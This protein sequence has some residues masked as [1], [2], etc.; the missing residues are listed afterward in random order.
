MNTQLPSNSR[1]S[2]LK[3]LT[4]T[5]AAG[6]AMPNLLLRAQDIPA[7]KKLG[8][9]CIGVGGKGFSDMTSAAWQNE[10]VAIC[11]VDAN[12]LAKA[13][14][15]FPNA[16]QYSDFREMLEKEKGIDG[17]T[18][19]T[20]DHSHYP[21]AMHAISLGKHICVQKPLVNT[22]WEARELHKAASKKGIITQMGNQ[23]HTYEENRLLKE[24]LDAGAIGKISEIHVWTNRQVWP[25][26]TATAP[27]PVQPVPD[28]LDWKLWLAQSPDADYRPQIHPFHWR[29]LFEYGAGALGDMGCHNLDPIV[30]ALGL[31]V[32]D[33]IEATAND[34]T[35]TAWPAGAK[36]EYV[37]ENV[38][39]HGAIKLYWYEGKNSDGSPCLPPPPEGLTKPMSNVGFYL[40]GADGIIHNEGSQ[41]QKFMILP[42][43]RSVEFL[44]NPPEKS[45]DR[46]PTPGDSQK[47]WSLAIK[48]GKPFPFM[49]QFD[50]AVPLTEL[51]LLGALSIRTGTAIRCDQEKYL[52]TGNDAA[53]RLIKRAQYREGWE[54]TA[55]KI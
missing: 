37:W 5:T 38:P 55:D 30:W 24:Y 15:K 7:G 9:G 12:M 44:A 45:L 39:G 16:R 27:K 53:N 8:I 42:E 50:Y 19:S 43:A 54:Y 33:R 52:A 4:A 17:V 29:G 49:S 20:P 18:I 1:R 28:T 22:L 31:G 13:A 26:G 47:E 36:V 25:Q 3:G 40:V 11:D 41:A 21:A 23:G 34:L 48:Q 46:S 32:P 6:I 14:G 2:F 10:I 51:C 35:A